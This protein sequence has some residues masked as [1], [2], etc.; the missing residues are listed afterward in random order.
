MELM[1]RL[2]PR[3]KTNPRRIVLPEGQDPRVLEAAAKLQRDAL[4]QPIVLGNPAQLAQAEAEAGISLRELNIPTLDPAT[5]D[6][7][8]RLATILFERRRAKGLTETQSA[9]IVREMPLYFGALML[10]AGMAD[11]MVA[12]SIASTADVLRAAF[13]CVGTAPGIRIGS[14][15]FVMDL[16]QPTESGDTTLLFA[17]CGVVPNPN[18]DQLVDIAQAT[19]LTYRALFSKRPI[20]GFLSFST[21]GSSDHPLVDKVRHATEHTL[22]RFAQ[23]QIDA[24]IDGELQA[25]AAL[26]PD[27]A[28]RKCPKSNVQGNANVLIFPDLQAGNIAYKLVQRLA[29]AR[30][31][32][33]ILQGLAKPI[34][35]LSRGCSARDIVGA[36][37]I[38]ICQTI[39]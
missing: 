34:N 8:N 1:H 16:V 30:A 39:G 26:V 28:A 5:S 21:K 14:S 25:D 36:T 17:D 12:G 32:G 19:A 37:L 27:I 29:G 7:G 24:V 2:A 18:A 4:C 38:T 10:N 13:H 33:P 35:D 9:A 3:A 23:M 6:E 31:Y 11:G 15:C 20:L 22:E